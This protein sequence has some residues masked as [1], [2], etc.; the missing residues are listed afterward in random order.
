MAKYHRIL[1]AVDGSDASFHALREAFKLVSNWVTVVAVAPFY[2]GDLRLVGVPRAQEL[3]REPCETALKKAQ[4]LAEAAGALLQ[5]VCVVGEPH[6]AIVEQADR[7]SRDLIVM[8]AKGHSFIERVMVGS[9]TQRV[10]GFTRRDVLVV[11]GEAAIGWERILLA[12]DGSPH[13][14]GAAARALDLAQ[15]YGG[16][17]SVLAVVEPPGGR[18]PE[19]VAAGSIWRQQAEALAAVIQSRAEALNLT[20]RGLVREG[21]AYEVI[22]RVAREEGVNLII[23]GS[24]GRTGLPRLLLGSVA[25]RVIGHAPCPVLVVKS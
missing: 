18:E 8:G 7:G 14:Q 6:E 10:I 21:R 12:T 19:A 22:T 3:I 16:S 9:V 11:P 15:S 1:V 25:E 13:S 20:A 24:H 2:E 17:L 23:L 4:A 5:P